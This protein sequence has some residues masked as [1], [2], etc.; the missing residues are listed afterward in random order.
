MRGG[1]RSNA[2]LVELLIVVAFFMLAATL[3]LQVFAASR[4]QSVRA[5]MIAQVIGEG[6]NV[7][8]RLYAAP[9][10]EACLTELGFTR[11]GETW[12]LTG[13]GWR[14]EAEVSQEE[15]LRRQQVTVY[16]D[17]QDGTVLLTLPCSRALEVSP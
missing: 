8:D 4:R 1:S 17:S 9:D 11:E 3:L 6:Q 14:V 2:L 10:A 16:E 5:E 7:A 13:E 12:S 15:G